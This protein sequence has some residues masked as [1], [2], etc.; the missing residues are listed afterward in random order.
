MQLPSVPTADLIWDEVGHP[1]SKNHNDVYYSRESGIEETQYVFLE[2]NHIAERL[3]EIDKRNHLTVAEI[4]FG[5]GLNFLCCWLEWHNQKINGDAVPLHFVSVENA[6][7]RA[8]DLTKALANWPALSHLSDQL[9]AQYPLPVKG[10]HRLVFEQGLVTLT[11]YI[12]DAEDQYNQAL[13]LADAWFLDGF[14]PHKSPEMWSP[15]LFEII[16][17]HS[18]QDA[19]F[20]TFSIAGVIRRGMTS[21]G[22]NVIKVPGFGRKK[23]MHAGYFVANNNTSVN[24]LLNLPWFKGSLGT[25]V[26]LSS[27]DYDAIIVGAGLA[28][29][30]TATALASRGLNVLVVE[31]QDAPGN[32]GSGNPQGALYNKFSSDFNVQTEYALNNLLFSQRF[33]HRTQQQFKT[34]FWNQ[35]GLIQVAWNEKE[36]KKQADFLSKNQYPE[37]LFTPIDAKQASQ[38]AGVELN[39]GGLFFPD[40]G[41]V[42][43]KKL[44]TLL[45]ESNDISTR[46]NT[47]IRALTQD[48]VSKI[49]TAIDCNNQTI[50]TAQNIIIC[51]ASDAKNVEQ[52]NHFK[53]KPIRGQVSVVNSDADYPL[54]TVLCGEG[55]ISPQT[56]HKFCFGATF[57]LKND[58]CEEI[59]EDHIKNISQLTEWLDS[60]K[61]LLSGKHIKTLE[62]RASQRCSSPDYVPIVGKAPNINEQVDRFSKL[63][64]DAKAKFDVSGAYYQGLFVNIAHGSKGLSSCPLAA[65]FIASQLCNEPS[66][67]SA[68]IVKAISPSRFIIRDLIRRK[69]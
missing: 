4:G 41:W 5:T 51:S 28:G 17:L 47:Q 21:A 25:P 22:F 36:K 26:N 59:K 10:C 23:E 35:C 40:S 9:I 29:A 52:L 61:A 60:A 33:Y 19:T 7:L 43:P 55:Y 63:R 24:Q 54:K 11:L 38:I 42:A 14:A 30:T 69:L 49:W 53:I 58:H 62:G 57:D 32:G 16:G 50:A 56:D 6:P 15:H 65:E 39:R 18:A 45:L 27:C 68:E 37:D 13:F 8:S 67:L 44:C 66:P 12:G 48:T 46:Y 31:K 34:V 2:H 20:S 1:I 64:H 3:R